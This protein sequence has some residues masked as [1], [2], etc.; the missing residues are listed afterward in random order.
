MW[1]RGVDLERFKPGNRSE[2]FRQKLGVEPECPIVLYVGRLVPEKRPDIIATVVKR[3]TA[4]NVK[5]ACVIV[6]AGPAEHLIENLPNTHHLG[7]LNGDQLTEA[8]ASSDI[9]LFPS[10]VETFG[11]VTLEAAA[12]GLPLVVEEKCSG[13]LVDHEQ[14]GYACQAGNVEAFFQGTLELCNNAEKRTLFSKNSI[15]KSKTLEQSVVVRQMLDNYKEVQKEFYDEFGGN[16]YNRDA[17]FDQKGSFVIGMDPRPTGW[18]LLE[19]VL[20]SALRL[21]NFLIGMVSQCHCCNKESY[22]AVETDEEAQISSPTQSVNEDE[23]KDG[24]GFICK[25]F[26]A[27]GDSP[28]TAQL[29]MFFIGIFLFFCRIISRIRRCF[30]KRL[31]SK[32]FQSIEHRMN[33][34]FTTSKIKH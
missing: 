23:E 25:I 26:V 7:W 22:E 31:C 8:Y 5:F 16:H 24:P 2:S 33:A 15:A 3:L 34:A 28:L 32:N 20:L 1:G 17:A 6:G 9:F 29:V 21:A 30:A 19:F 4:Q 13:H 27:I 10:S 18:F 12:S 14:N 11:N